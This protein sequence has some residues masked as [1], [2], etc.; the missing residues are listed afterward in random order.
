MSVK[1]EYLCDLCGDR[2]NPDGTNGVGIYWVS[3]N[4]ERRKVTDVEHHLCNCCIRAVRRFEV[5]S[6]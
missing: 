2:I 4:I 6:K 1:R 5:E 3:S